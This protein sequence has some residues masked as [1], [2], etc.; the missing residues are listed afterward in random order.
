[1]VGLVGDTEKRATGF[2]DVPTTMAV[3]DVETLVP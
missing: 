2:A 3:T 1:M